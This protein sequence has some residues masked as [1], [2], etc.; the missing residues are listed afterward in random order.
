[1]S[2][3]VPSSDSRFVALVSYLRDLGDVTVAFSGG[4]DSAFLAY[5]A[6]ISLGR[7]A[8]QL[9]TAVSPSLGSGEL[10][11]C[12]DLARLWDIPFQ[13]VQTAEMENP[14]YI[15]N[16]Y[17]RC[18]WCKVELMDAIRPIIK[19][20]GSKV[21]LGVNLDDLGDFRP[22]QK[23]A[24]EA[25]ARFPLVDT[26]YTKEMIRE[27]SRM[28]GLSTWERPQ[29]ACLSSRI[30]YGTSVSIPV[31]SQIDRAEAYLK[32]LGFAQVRVRHYDTTARIEFLLE[33]FDKVLAM[34]SE[35]ISAV[36]NVGYRYVTMDLEGF[37]SGNLNAKIVP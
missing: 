23:A 36:R 8:V 20:T 34:R 6:R 5:V 28:L 12:R 17:D 27:H 15:A 33:D 10:E 29:S 24:R 14:N 16:G 9:V 18:Y 31:L 35:I 13:T 26:G 3:R 7:A 25:G 4:V 19:A 11:H 21:V 37:R 1:M 32:Q 2:Y 22:G 30:P